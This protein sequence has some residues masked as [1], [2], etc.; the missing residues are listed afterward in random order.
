M[1]GKRKRR[2]TSKQMG[3]A[4][5]QLVAA[6][7]TLVGDIPSFTVPVD[8]PGY[9]VVATPKG[10]P[11]QRVSVKCRGTSS[12]QFLPSVLDWLAIVL[13][14]TTPFKYFVIPCKV[15]VSRSRRYGTVKGYRT[16]PVK[17]VA[18]I[19]REYENNWTLREQPLV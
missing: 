17:N 11:L 6:N 1:T 2:Y 4:A 16:V 14:D 9:D 13:I 12:I 5:E 18:S 3:A 10:K 19:F 15:A 7:L 8:W